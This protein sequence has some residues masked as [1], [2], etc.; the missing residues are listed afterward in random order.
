MK[1]QKKNLEVQYNAPQL[2]VLIVEVE[3]GFQGS[4]EDVGGEKGEID[5]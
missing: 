5:W 3:S 2:D 4:L 1:M